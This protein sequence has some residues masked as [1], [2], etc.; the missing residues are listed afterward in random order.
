MS[1]QTDIPAVFEFDPPAGGLIR[2][3][4][5]KVVRAPLE[6][7]LG[8]GRLQDIYER[9]VRLLPDCQDFPTATLQ[10][11][12]ISLDLA[13]GSLKSI[14]E[15]GPVVVVANHPFGGVEGVALLSLLRSVRP[16]TKVLA[17][18]MLGR[19]PEMDEHSIYVDPF[20]GDS[21]PRRNIRP[22]KECMSWLREGHV[23]ASFPSGEVS[24]L[25]LSRRRVCDPQ[26]SPH[27]GRLVRKMQ[28]DVLPVFFCGRNGNLFQLLG[29][30]HP[31]C[32]TALLARA[33]VGQENHVL[34]VRVGERLPFTRLEKRGD[35]A[36]LIDYLRFRTY[37]QGCTD[38]QPKRS[39]LRRRCAP[40]AVEDMEP[41]VGP[42]PRE[43][44]L[45]EVAALGDEGLLVENK[46]FCV[47]FA[48]AHQVPCAL[49]EIGRLREITFRTEGEGTGKSIDLDAFD[50]NYQHLFLW[51]KE[52]EQIAGAYRMAKTDRILKMCGRSGLYTNTLF[53]FR[54]K[55]WK[56]LGPSWE[57]G[58]SFIC[59]E[60]QRNPA[61][62]LLMWKGIGCVV[63]REPQYKSL[64]GPVSINNEYR[65]V[66]R[67]L[68]VAFLKLGNY[69]RGL[70]KLVKARNP[71][72]TR[73]SAHTDGEVL[74]RAAVDLKDVSNLVAEIEENERG[75]P[76]L[77][78]QY[79]R[80]G[81]KL[82]GFNI[83][84]DFQDVLDGLIWVDLSETD[85]RLLEKFFG[86]EGA[87]EFFRFHGKHVED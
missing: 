15:Q 78:K 69:E 32:R 76:I 9:A 39:K 86:R 5:F 54:P 18:Y 38:V 83:D 37:F 77:L 47:Y 41:V 3:A 57:M 4:L 10:A 70:A 48:E 44:I 31:R 49:R 30:I 35:D 8:L 29:L 65:S 64:F 33:L 68:M 7:A 56:Q 63:K 62:L 20:G 42:Q 17:N 71:L 51:H 81:G 12:N 72:R 74:S 36:S 60:F 58:R 67:E 61:A 16:D 24:H 73:P 46:G 34:E 85:P 25:Q 43:E 26:W 13:P 55:L 22:M 66:S 6:H 1:T 79:L 53:K 40:I 11:M 52:S 50:V 27:I 21:A 19:M 82:I 14:P 2:R 59:T 75:V 28:V 45:R 23:L 87:R 80:L 84:P